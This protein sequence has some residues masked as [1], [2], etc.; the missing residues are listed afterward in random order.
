MEYFIIYVKVSLLLGLV[1]FLGSSILIITEYL[2]RD[3]H[4]YD[5]KIGRCS[6]W[7]DY[8]KANF[9]FVIFPFGMPFINQVTLLFF[10]WI[11]VSGFVTAWSFRQ[12]GA[13]LFTIFTK[14]AVSEEVSILPC[15]CCGGTNL[16]HFVNEAP[17]I[18]FNHRHYITCDNCNE[19]FQM[20]AVHVTNAVHDWNKR[21]LDSRTGFE[22]LK[23]KWAYKH[24]RRFFFGDKSSAGVYK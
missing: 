18:S 8:Y 7:W 6:N 21:Y 12:Y 1:L 23:A 5:P 19:R 3:K 9:W 24:D 14:G 20:D 17:G 10:A 16:R 11:Y 15:R 4:S 22:K 13:K 2:R